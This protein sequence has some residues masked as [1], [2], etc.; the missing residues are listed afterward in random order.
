MARP[1]LHDAEQRRA[2]RKELRALHR[3]WRWLGLA[4]IA[5]AIIILFVRGG[6]FDPLSLSLLVV[7]WA[8]LVGVI[9][10]RTR[11]HKARMAEP[12]AGDHQV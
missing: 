2:Y 3:P 8:V 6:G 7:G 1:D 10:A 4:I 11:Y 5:V 9:I 12:P